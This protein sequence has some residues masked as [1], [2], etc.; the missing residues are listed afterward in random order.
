MPLF[1][2]KP[3]FGNQRHIQMAESIA[4]YYK[5]EKEYDTCKAGAKKMKRLKEEMDRIERSYDEFIKAT[6]S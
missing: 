3:A 6:P 4:K 5:L 1:K 2:F